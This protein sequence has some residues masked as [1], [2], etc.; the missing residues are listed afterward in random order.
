MEERLKAAAGALFLFV[1]SQ[2]LVLAQG[3]PLDTFLKAVAGIEVQRDGTSPEHGTGFVVSVDGSIVTLLTARHLFF[4]GPDSYQ[5]N[6]TVTFY[7]DK[8]HQPPYKAIWVDGSSSLDVAIIRVENVPLSVT[9]QFPVFY[10]RADEKPISREDSVRVFG[11]E[12]EQWQTP[13]GDITDDGDA[14]S[15]D[16]FR[17]DGK[18]TRA[19]FSGAPVLDGNRLLIGIHLGATDSEAAFGRA[20][21]M[22]RVYEVATQRLGVKM[23]KVAMGPADSGTASGGPGSITWGSREPSAGTVKLN[24]KDGLNYVWIPPGTFTMGCSPGDKE[25]YRNE[26]PAHQVTITKGFWMGQT[27][28]TQEACQRVRGRNPN[29]FKGPGLPVDSIRWRD[30]K[31][32]C[33]AVGMRLPSEAEWEYAARAGT[34]GARY[35]DLNAIA[36]YGGRRTH[37]VGTK[38]P[39]AW[40]LY[41]MLGNVEQWTADWYGETYYDQRVAR[42]PQ[43]PA[44][45]DNRTLRGGSWSS[46]PRG[47][48]V[49]VR[50][51]ANPGDRYDGTGFRCVGETLP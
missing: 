46:V 36:W 23:N 9:Q 27:P 12:S 11:G 15:L 32:Y 47:L 26:S 31:Q 29:D 5:N 44:G 17:F 38:Q 3:P 6:G 30:A 34:T 24:T 42:D 2:V 45:G 21:R 41:D 51:W 8:H 39:N 33:E 14:N 50:S 19:G 48:R 22:S 28:V 13:G 1:L 18:G 4:I 35:G 16:G 43:G 20:V 25:C 49:S 40:G 7:L 37:P 10:L